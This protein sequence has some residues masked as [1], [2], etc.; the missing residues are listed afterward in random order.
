MTKASFGAVLRLAVAP[1]SPV[2]IAKINSITP[3]A[4]TRG[5]LDSTN[6]DNSDDAMTFIADGVY[7]PGEISIGGDLIMG[8]AADD[9][10]V[11]AIRSGD[12]HNFE[13]EGFAATGREEMSG[14]CVVTAYTPGELSVT[15]KQT[16]T[17]TLK[18]SGAI[19]QAPVV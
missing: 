19:T 8:S 13:I 16:F 10:F 2:A 4:M 7:D 9:L 15:G 12:L 1:G 11:A 17:A 18:V 5:T 14:V 6:H 3:P